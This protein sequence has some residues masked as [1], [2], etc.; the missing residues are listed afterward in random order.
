MKA[1]ELRQMYI[2]FF[3]KRGHKA[4]ASA[5]L[6]P[7]NDPSVLFTTAGMHPLI[8]YLIGEKHPLGKRLVNVQK[9]IRTCDI[10]EDEKGLLVDMNGF[11][12]KFK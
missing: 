8:P 10:D 11:E 4:I 7:D 5:S 3:E 1:N 12:E 6:L 9:C 2:E